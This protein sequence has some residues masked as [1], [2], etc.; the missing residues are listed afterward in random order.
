MSQKNPKLSSIKILCSHRNQRNHQTLKY[1]SPNQI[2]HN[3]V[4]CFQ[5]KSHK[6]NPMKKNLKTFSLKKSKRK[7]KRKQIQQYRTSNQNLSLN[8]SHPRSTKTK[9]AL[10]TYTR[11]SFKTRKIRDY[12]TDQK[13]KLIVVDIITISWLKHIHPPTRNELAAIEIDWHHHPRYL[14]RRIH[15]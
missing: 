12:R 3:L 7:R 6:F 10:N 1:L 9:E 2:L 13:V 15:K 4:L 8:L 5:H 11:Y 14:T